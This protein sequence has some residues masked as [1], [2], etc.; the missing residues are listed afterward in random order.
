M[1]TP[2]DRAI[3]IIV[4]LTEPEKIILFG[5]RATGETKPDSDYDLFVIKKDVPHRRKL[6]QQIYR[7]LYG[8]GIPIDVIVETPDRFETLKDNPFL[9]YKD[10]ERRGKVLY[11]KPITVERVAQKS[12]KQPGTS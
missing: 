9:I 10:I 8:I 5:S 7:S 2:I 11:E 12:K 6:A 3:E 4:N 1:D